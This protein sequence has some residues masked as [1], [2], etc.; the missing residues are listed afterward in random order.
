M[1]EIP[2]RSRALSSAS[3]TR[4]VAMAKRTVAQ[5]VRRACSWW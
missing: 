4:I 2:S 1:R 3:T 5:H